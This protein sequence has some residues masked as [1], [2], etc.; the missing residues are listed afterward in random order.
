MGLAAS[1]VRKFA[2]SKKTVNLNSGLR[3][4]AEEIVSKIARRPQSGIRAFYVP[5]FGE[6]TKH[7]FCHTAVRKCNLAQS[8]VTLWCTARP[9]VEKRVL[10]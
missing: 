5:S 2:C 8:F 6:Q 7:H 10:L 3:R 1:F 4:E 9:S